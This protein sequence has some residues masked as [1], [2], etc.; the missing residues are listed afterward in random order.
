MVS[1]IAKDGT[2]RGGAR[3]GSGR[4]P[5]ALE[6]KIN[7][8]NPGGRKLTT[9]SL[10]AEATTLEGSNMPEI[11]DYL[12]SKQKD[13]S[14]LLTEELYKELWDWLKKYNCENLVMPQIMEQFV[15]V[16]ARLIH[17]EEAISDFGYLVKKANG[18][19]ATSPYVTMSN[20][21]RKQANQLYYQMYQIIKENSSVEVGNLTS[22]SDAMEMLLR[23]KPRKRGE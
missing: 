2:N 12:K 19:A 13:G 21:Y 15:M 1:E 4:K 20:E 10:G 7:T 11:K 23:Q 5:K 8:G 6:E 22:S 9:I 17:C 3:T 18:S 14:D 16:S